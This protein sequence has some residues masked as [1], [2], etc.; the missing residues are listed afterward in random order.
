MRITLVY[1][2]IGNI[3]SYNFGLG[4]IAAYLKRNGHDVQGL[5]INPETKDG[6]ELVDIEN[7]ITE[8][9]PG[10]IAFSSVSN[11]FEFVKQIANHL[12]DKGL[13]SKILVGGIH[14][15]ISPEN[16]LKEDSIDMVCLGE[17]EETIIELADKLHKN[18]DISK[19]RNIWLK[20][21]N[22]IIKNELRPLIK[23][24]GILP[25][26]DRTMFEFG[27]ILEKKRGWV[28]ILAGR[29]CP[30]QCNYCVNHF[31][32]KLNKGKCT[33]RLRPVEHVLAEIAEIE[34]NHEIKMLNFNDDTF[35]INKEWIL[36]FCEEY[37]KR[38]RY[39]FA[40]N[41]R[42]TNF[43]EELALAL[44]KAGCAEIKIG[45]ESGSKRIREEV[46]N[47]YM[48]NEQIERAFNAAKK[49]GIRTWSFNMVGMPTETKEELLETI[50]LNA[51]IRPY[52]LRCSILFPYK[53]TNLYEKCVKN[54]ILDE[55]KQF[56]YA[57]YF[58]G[59]ILKLEHLSEADI[60]R[61]K[62]MFKWYVDAHSDIEVADFYKKLIGLFEKLPD[63]MWI[64]GEAQK[65]FKEVDEK[66]DNLFKILKKEH[67]SSR[68]H[69]DLKFSSETNWEL[70]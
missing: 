9:N 39:F 16:I 28:N 30:Y 5:H 61:Y 35:T 11:Q 29:G 25:F 17:G 50:K 13:N 31:L 67:Y 10:L 37:P 45:L 53:G 7:Q 3:P 55:G 46:L 59:T 32:T 60:L 18:E 27:E 36:K 68:S 58:E 33:L 41:A 56:K 63:N 49:A 1:P 57:S 70:P 40:C 42:A 2:N 8:F 6:I 22:E 43:D 48:T 66:I 62:T 15:T 47:R 38:F 51:K 24:L 65:L 26:A 44:K 23:D 52:I 34:K 21:N 54:G 64:E 12:K 20:K 4:I 14:A 69:L 19:I